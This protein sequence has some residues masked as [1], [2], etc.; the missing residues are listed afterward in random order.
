M[1]NLIVA[2][3]V[4]EPIA[5]G[6]FLLT[7]IAYA[8]KLFLDRQSKTETR[9]ESLLD[10]VEEALDAAALAR[11]TFRVLAYTAK[12]SARQM[13]RKTGS[14]VGGERFEEVCNTCDKAAVETVTL[15]EKI[16][17]IDRSDSSH[18]NYMAARVLR[19]NARSSLKQATKMSDAIEKVYQTA[20][21]TIDDTS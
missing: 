20:E 21:A 17:A 16:L 4:N 19:A 18:K 12:T 11:T 5:A 8:L 9:L 14:E 1:P 3:V 6:G 7:W 2:A 13:M 10:V 15:S